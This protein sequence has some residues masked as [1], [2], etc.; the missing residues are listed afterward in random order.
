VQLVNFSYQCVSACEL[1]SKYVLKNNTCTPC[2]QNMFRYL[3]GSCLPEGDGS[4]DCPFYQVYPF[5]AQ[6][7]VSCAVS[8]GLQCVA[9]CSS[10]VPFVENGV[11]SASCSG[12]LFLARNSFQ[13]CQKSCEKVKKFRVGKGELGYG[14]F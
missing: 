13:I 6:C 7:E 1:A 8:E 10:R 5:Y 12:K 3:N 9:E 4:L 14:Y 2:T 11:C